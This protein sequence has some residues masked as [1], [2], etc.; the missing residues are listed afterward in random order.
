M[1]AQDAIEYLAAAHSNTNGNPP[2]YGQ[3][4]EVIGQMKDYIGAQRSKID[5]LEMIA[6]TVSSDRDALA[7]AVKLAYR[8]H[9]MGDEDVG[10]NELSDRLR[11]ALC[12]SMGD[13]GYQR[14]VAELEGRAAAEGSAAENG[15]A[16]SGPRSQSTKVSDRADGARS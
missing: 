9:H 4:A 16:Q 5:K 1:N 11:D 3:I 14:W 10:W 13:V 12:N 2:I 6:E 7:E 15:G 8:K